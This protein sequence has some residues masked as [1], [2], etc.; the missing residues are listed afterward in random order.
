MKNIRSEDDAIQSMKDME[1]LIDNWIQE[2]HSPD[3]NEL[4]RL[5]DNLRAIRTLL[6]RIKSDNLSLTSRFNALQNSYDKLKTDAE[7]LEC[8]VGDLEDK[9]LQ[10]ET[11]LKEQKETI[12]KLGGDAAII[13]AATILSAAEN[14]FINLL[15]EKCPDQREYYSKVAD[16]LTD[17]K[18]GDAH[19][20]LV[21][22]WELFKHYWPRRDMQRICREISQS[23]GV[24]VH[25]EDRDPTYYLNLSGVQVK[26][27]LT[28]TYV[29]SSI[30]NNPELIPNK[31][32]QIIVELHNLTAVKDASQINGASEKDDCC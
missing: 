11:S 17:I 2:I 14:R 22:Q 32:V 16:C 15:C 29:Q 9:V 6:E 30:A 23:R 10:M 27:T 1:A 8:K 31:L 3:L 21:K 28:T 25:K 7:A 24:V 19:P 12:E 4:S 20:E 18:Y 5:F 13:E 26:N